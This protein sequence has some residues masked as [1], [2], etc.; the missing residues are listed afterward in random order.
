MVLKFEIPKNVWEINIKELKVRLELVL[1][2]KF[3]NML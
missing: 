1:S 3:I 2:V